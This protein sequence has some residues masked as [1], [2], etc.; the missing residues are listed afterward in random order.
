M[1]LDDKIAAFCQLGELMQDIDNKKWTEVLGKAYEN[2]QWFNISES[3]KAILNLSAMLSKESIV[4]W[5]EDYKTTTSPKKVGII[6]AGNIPLVN[7]HDLLC[8]ILSGN[9]AYCK[10][11]HKD[12]LLM[13]FIIHLL[14]EINNDFK[15]Y[16]I[17]T[18]QLKNIDAVIATGSNNTFRYFDAYFGKNPHIFRKSRT[19]IAIL[20]G[21][22]SKDDYN[23]LGKDIFDYYGF[24]CR[25]VSKIYI[26]RN[27]KPEK[28]LANMDK[29]HMVIDN[30]KYKNNFDYNLSI[31]LLNRTPHLHNE[32]MIIQES[33]GIFTPTASIYYEYYDT[34]EQLENKL[35]DYNNDIQC[36]V[37][38]NGF[39][40]N[41]FN[42]GES[43]RPCLTDYP[44]HVDSMAFLEGL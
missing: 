20:N 36:I 1:I 8:V 40:K 4:R 2:N 26:P 34:I 10:L 23:S 6:M 28:I 43:Q 42:L 21:N 38:T 37:S 11:S 14:I 9:I 16:I 7:F 17:V 33:E 3:R 15:D 32:F 18:E 29:F 25:N 31:L 39:Y 27:F 22:E 19:S 44:D 5:L 13:N 41:S 12:S 24:G 30:N 35:S